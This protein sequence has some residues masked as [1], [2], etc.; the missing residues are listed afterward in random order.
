MRTL[1]ELCSSDLCQM[2][3]V[4]LEAAQLKSQIGPQPERRDASNRIR[5]K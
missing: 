1:S 5:H 3:F 4:R 2:A